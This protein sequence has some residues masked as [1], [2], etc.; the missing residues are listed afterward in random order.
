MTLDTNDELLLTMLLLGFLFFNGSLLSL[1]FST[2]SEGFPDPN[3]GAI[4]SRG[5][6]AMPFALCEPESLAKL[7]VSCGDSW[8]LGG[9][10]ERVLAE[11]SSRY[12]REDEGWRGARTTMDSLVPALGGDMVV[13]SG[14]GL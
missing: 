10:C 14:L 13:A 8:M 7:F 1:P 9:T 3:A 6:D 4:P 11:V 5:D 2:A 12:N